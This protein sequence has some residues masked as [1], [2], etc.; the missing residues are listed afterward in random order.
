VQ[1]EDRID[2]RILERALLHHQRRA[3]FLSL[4]RAFFR[5]LKEKLDRPEDLLAH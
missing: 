5:R 3:S 1:P 4:R 2:F